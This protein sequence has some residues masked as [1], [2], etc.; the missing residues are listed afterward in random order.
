V[1]EPARRSIVVPE[2]FDQ[3]EALRAV[4]D[5]RFQRV[6]SGN[7]ETFVWDYWHVPGQ[8]TYLRTAGERYFPEEL[9]KRF[10]AQ[11]RDW[12]REVLGCEQPTLPRLSYYVDGCMQELH[13]DVPHGPWAYVFSLTDW[14]HRSFTGGE[15]MLVRPET[16]DF[17]RG[18]DPDRGLEAD[19]LIERI[20]S[21]FNQL[22]VF[23]AR[24][25]HGV[26][27][28]RGTNDPLD[29]RVV[30]HG[31]FQ[32]PE[33]VVSEDLVGDRAAVA[34][35]LVLAHVARRIQQSSSVA[36]LLT[37]RVEFS[38]KGRIGNTTVLTNTLVSTADDSTDSDE[39]VEIILEA[40]GDPTIDVPE[41]SW[42]ILPIRLP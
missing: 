40:L 3:A 42:A 34:L 27:H 1:S 37:V 30:L 2:F 4:F 7:P 6:R 9:T 21:R 22:T 38:E 14:E 23:D 16:L 33:L 13:A 10:L 15:T 11:L 28:V 20:P 24:I 31:W 18:L 25:P 39:I 19:D 17:W 36:G 8:Y 41:G 26:A 32:Y 35:Q 12:G 5:D 29:S